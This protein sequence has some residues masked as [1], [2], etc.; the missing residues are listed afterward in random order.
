MTLWLLFN[1]RKTY[2]T[3]EDI[4]GD[5]WLASPVL[6]YEKWVH[7]TFNEIYLSYSQSQFSVTWLMK[8][9][10]IMSRNF[11]TWQRKC[12]M[13]LKQFQILVK[14]RTPCRR[15]TATVQSVLTPS[16]RMPLLGMSCIIVTLFIVQSTVHPSSVQCFIMSSCRQR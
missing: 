3:A 13:I 14:L 1:D 16:F 5:L 15:L 7:N 4:F 9:V 8:V 2:W 6:C 11:V 12:Q 10:L